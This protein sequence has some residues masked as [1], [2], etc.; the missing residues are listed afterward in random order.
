L[1]VFGLRLVPPLNASAF[2]SHR[3]DRLKGSHIHLVPKQ[4]IVLIEQNL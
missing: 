4:I 2:A 3:P 1:T